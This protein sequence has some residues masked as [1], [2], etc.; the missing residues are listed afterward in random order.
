LHKK[1]YLNRLKSGELTWYNCI[2]K[3]TGSINPTI[4]FT[5]FCHPKF[6]EIRNIFY[7]NGKKIIPI[8]YIR[9]KYTA[10]SLAMHYLDDGHKRTGSKRSRMI[11][12]DSFPPDNL[13]EYCDFII[14]KF[15]INVF[16]IDKNRV[17]IDY[18]DSEKFVNLIAPY[19]PECMR[20]KL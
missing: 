6:N 7:P 3:S 10:Q 11:C 1:N 13:Q 2:I 16:I 12:T 15:G 17:R 14:E 9:D 8:D 4:V 20:Y 19:T 18:R 5:T